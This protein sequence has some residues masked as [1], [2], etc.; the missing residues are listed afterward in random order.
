MA[1]VQ[2]I[3]HKGKKILYLDFSRCKSVEL[4]AIVQEAKRV[5]GTQ[6]QGSVRTLPM[7][8]DLTTF[9]KPFVVAAV[10]GVAGL[11]KVIYNAIVAL[12]GRNMSTFDTIEQ[13]KEWLATP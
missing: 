5:I 2:F 10:V 3:E 7:V 4:D 11:K 8:K 9:N 1:R 6:A 13:A 12:S